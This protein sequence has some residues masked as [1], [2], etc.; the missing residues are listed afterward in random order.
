MGC[1]NN[2]AFVNCNLMLQ[3]FV[4]VN[5]FSRKEEIFYSMAKYTPF[6]L[7]VKTKLLAHPTLNQELL[8]VEINERTGLKVDGSLISKILTGQKNSPR[9]IESICEILEIHVPTE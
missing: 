1:T 5:M 9:A 7:A 3:M 4:R 6:G 8:A 2:S